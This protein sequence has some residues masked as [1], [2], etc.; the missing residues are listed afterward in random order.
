MPQ[1]DNDTEIVVANATK[2]KY[3]R[4][5]AHVR[6]LQVPGDPVRMFVIGLSRGG[7]KIETWVNTKNLANARIKHIPKD[8]L[9]VV[10]YHG[11]SA[12][13]VES[14]INNATN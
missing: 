9:D 3:L 8:V 1:T 13:K 11:R 14:I 2:H 7:R 10:C 4:R 12:Q 5:N 6:I